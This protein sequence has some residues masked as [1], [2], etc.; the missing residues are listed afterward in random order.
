MDIARDICTDSFYIV[1]SGLPC[2]LV[3][4]VYVDTEAHTE[5]NFE[6]TRH[7]YPWICS[8]RTKGITAE[9]ICA[10]TL[11]SLPPQPTIIIGP[12]HCTYLCKDG[13]PTGAR[14]EAC[15]CTPQ[16]NGCS[17][18]RIRCGRNPGAVEMDPSEMIILCGEYETGPTP[19][20]FFFV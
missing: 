17:E 8:L 3:T 14:L 19:I 4:A 7:R 5:L 1:N 6:N 16:P 13:G 18:N 12:A 9:H 11:L 2:I 15:C 20:R 10:V